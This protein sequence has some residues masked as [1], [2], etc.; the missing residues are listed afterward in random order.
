MS[1]T[2]AALRAFA[3]AT[4]VILPVLAHAGFAPAQ[5]ESGGGGGGGPPTGA[6]GG[7]LAGTYPNPT[8]QLVRGV[9]PGLQAAYD[10]GAT[11]T[12]GGAG[13]VSIA[14]TSTA[15]SPVLDL[16]Q[17]AVGGLALQAIGG[18]SIAQN[19]TSTTATL[20]LN[21]TPASSTAGSNL[22]IYSGANS[23]DQ[24]IY[25]AHD[26]TGTGVV[27]NQFG[28]GQGVAVQTVGSNGIAVTT[29]VAQTVA[30]VTVNGTAGPGSGTGLAVTMTTGDTGAV[31]VSSEMVRPT[32]MLANNA[33]FGFAS[34]PVQHA[35][36]A[37]GSTTVC[38]FGANT[39]TR[40]IGSGS[41]VV[42]NLYIG[43]FSGNPAY[44]IHLL[45]VQD[46]LKLGA[47]NVLGGTWDYVTALS[48]FLL[49]SSSLIPGSVPFLQAEDGD[50]APVSSASTGSIRYSLSNNRWEQSLNGAAWT[51]FGGGGVSD[52][53]TAY[54]GGRTIAV[55]SSVTPVAITGAGSGVALVV[56]SG[57]ISSPGAGSGSERFGAGATAAGVGA[58]AVGPSAAAPG[59]GA[60]VLGGSAS[61]AAGTVVAGGGAAGGS[62]S[63]V[64]IGNGASDGGSASDS[65]T[66]VGELGI[67]SGVLATV[68]GASGSAAAR[69]TSVGASADS[70]AFSFAG[71]YDASAS[72]SGAIALGYGSTTTATNQLV[73][74]SSVNA[75]T[76]L[77]FGNGVTNGTPSST[78]T[79]RTTGGTGAGDAGT[80]LRLR[81]GVSGD[82]STASG[83]ILLGVAVV[84][85]ATAI[86]DVLKIDGTTGQAVV[87]GDL[88][89]STV[90]G[91][92]TVATFN[93]EVAMKGSI[94]PV[95]DN[96]FNLGSA[97]YRW[98]L[99]RGV[100]ITSGLIVEEERFASER[101]VGEARVDALRADLDASKVGALDGRHLPRIALTSAQHVLE[102][103]ARLAA[104]EAR[105]A[106]K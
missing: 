75:I 88:T 98:A 71:G 41:N 24:G 4:L 23:T 58:L 65:S 26:G 20:Q 35:G 101:L 96:T 10:V 29:T 44:D 18:V 62:T 39:P 106:N 22:S 79:I 66:V 85:S 92:G 53:Q 5:G 7:D 34:T 91:A 93:G 52:L 63:S 2:T 84:S 74:G 60:V 40:V 50:L 12:T 36:D 48:P 19:D 94:L 55:L 100:T 54:N 6:A 1:R 31:G 49:S 25:L 32:P 8:V 87:G 78:V 97:S 70:G 103:E 90:P 30:L 46:R 15:T 37:A 76:D 72:H 99:I 45:A 21:K 43:D 86:T 83:G 38:A 81:T 56:T 95:A 14:A 89:A 51:A 28:G 61:G 80:G 105:L 102:L 17:A 57:V 13:A 27:V 9:A 77:V 64:V 16:S 59:D 69:G 68:V 3:I 67:S 73:S 33:T 42:G 104:L 82:A 47:L 11:I